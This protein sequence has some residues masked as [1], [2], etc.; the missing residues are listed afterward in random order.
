M[1]RPTVLALCASLVLLVAPPQRFARAAEDDARRE[2]GRFFNAGQQAYLKGEN[3]AAIR[4]FARSLKARPHPATRFNLAQ[5]CRRQ[6]ERDRDVRRLKRAVELYRR[7]VRESPQAS[8]RA[9][10]D[11]ELLQALALLAREPTSQPVVERPPP[12]TMLMITVSPPNAR[13]RIDGEPRV[14]EIAPAIR[15][16]KAGP[17]DVEVFADGFKRAK[18]RVVAVTGR[19]VLGEI[20]LEPAPG[21]L[22]VVSNVDGATVYV[23]GRVLGRTPFERGGFVPGGHQIAVTARGHRTWGATLRV[24]P[25]RTAV[26]VA[27]LDWSTQRVLALGAGGLSLA[28]ATSALITGVLALDSDSSL[29][30]LPRQ[31]NAQREAWDAQLFR[32][33]RLARA[34]TGLLISAGVAF[35][36]GLLLYFLDAGDAPTVR[37]TG[38]GATVKF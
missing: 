23:D 5:S 2:A 10:A 12:S 27:N 33:D 17:H 28:L 22:R 31:T 7:A 9:T 18:R 38:A 24:E 16:V 29:D 32:R 34:T 26:T 36:G 35:A 14:G 1:T 11:S 25:Q 3:L 30:S 8:W 21:R 15:V 4:A 19:L 20:K 37:P 13:V 6:F